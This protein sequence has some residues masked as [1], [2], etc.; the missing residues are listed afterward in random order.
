[1]QKADGDEKDSVQ[2]PDSSRP[3]VLELFGDN[4]YPPDDLDR[5]NMTKA[6]SVTAALADDSSLPI[7]LPQS[8]AQV[9]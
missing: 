2:I 6:P 3:S 8:R 7:T 4:N 5:L 1:M 9:N